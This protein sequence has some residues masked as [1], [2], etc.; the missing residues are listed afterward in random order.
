[1]LACEYTDGR[2]LSWDLLCYCRRTERLAL[3]DCHG[4]AVALGAFYATG[5]GGDVALG[6][7]AT[8]GQPKTLEAAQKLVRKAC[9]TAIKLNV[10][11][12]GAIRIVTVKGKRAAIEVS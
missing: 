6:V 9:A 7:L 4:S 2:P 3:L 10:A 5:S 1:M 12:G 11:C 8:A